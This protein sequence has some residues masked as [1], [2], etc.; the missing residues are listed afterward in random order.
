MIVAIG[1][2]VFLAALL[3]PALSK[4]KDGAV[5]VKCTSNQR[6]L[7]SALITYA[8]DNDMSFPVSTTGTNRWYFRVSN[9]VSGFEG[10]SVVHP[11]GTGV[12]E[13][14]AKVVI[15]PIPEHAGWKDTAGTYGLHEGF[16]SYDSGLPG[17]YAPVRLTRIN[18]TSTLPV[19]CCEGPFTGGHKMTTSGPNPWA[20]EK[21]GYDGPAR[22]FG[23]GPNHGGKCNFAFLDGHIEL[24]DVTKKD[25][26]PWNDPKVFSFE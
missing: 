8:Q 16:G 21:Y 1:I 6:A 10:S 12:K 11:S 4:S 15:C 17:D 22:I 7:I 9:Y 20:R 23:P 3:F 24:R 26:W 5:T 25:Q 2:V 13:S 14:Y 19:L 18:R